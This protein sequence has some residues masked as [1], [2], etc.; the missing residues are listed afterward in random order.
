MSQLVTGEAV[1]LQVRIARMPT[2]ALACAIDMVLQGIVLTVL[3]ALLA[4]FLFGSESSE[5]LAVALIFIVVL[6]VVVGYRVVMETLTR[7]RTL[8][9]MVLG[10]KVVR[11][12][13]SSIRFRHAL[14]R[15]LMWF[16]VDFAPWFAASPGI[17]AS[18]MNK[19]GKR[20]GDMVAGTVVIRERHQ[21]MASPP[22]FVPGH[23]VQWAQSLE[24]SRLSDEL[25]NAARDY[26]SRYAELLPGAQYALGEALAA[27]VAAVIAPAP[28][29]QIIAPAYLSAVLAER[30]RRELNR[31]STQHPTPTGPFTPNPYA[32]PAPSYAVPAGP[33]APPSPYG[34]LPPAPPAPGPF[35]PPAPPSAA[36]P[37]TVNTQG[38]A[39]PG[40][41]E[42]WS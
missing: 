7:G 13:G 4:G 34:V 32:A 31:L 35:A 29:T 9:K 24:L 38:W 15:T 14:V 16:F 39:V 5:A 8:G 28:P 10:L 1:V 20:I 12:D 40:S 37:A 22:L 17:V 3:L 33:F 19:Q 11:D 2:R 42:Q 6:L 36:R 41:N 25:A 21:S 23:L 26:L 27:R 18:L 30:R